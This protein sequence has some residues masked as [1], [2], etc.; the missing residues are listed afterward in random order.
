MIGIYEYIDYEVLFLAF[1]GEPFPS[2]IEE[3]LEMGGRFDGS[4]PITVNDDATI[5]VAKA[6]RHLKACYL[7][8]RRTDRIA[9]RIHR[10]ENL[11]PP[12]DPHEPE[13][14]RITEHT[15]NNLDALR[16]LVKIERNVILTIGETIKFLIDG[17]SP[18]FNLGN[19]PND[20]IVYGIFRTIVSVRMQHFAHAALKPTEPVKKINISL[21]KAVTHTLVRIMLEEGLNSIDQ[22]INYLIEIINTPFFKELLSVWNIIYRIDLKN[23]VSSD[24][25]TTNYLTDLLHGNTDPDEFIASNAYTIMK[26]VELNP[27]ERYEI[28]TYIKKVAEYRSLSEMINRFSVRPLHLWPPTWLGIRLSPSTSKP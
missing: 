25:Y 4:M 12:S 13:N 3:Y 15:W 27:E 10:L 1:Y 17:T 18:L 22:T 11:K 9:S 2:E 20:T 21:P 14:I 8:K 19:T 28:L 6:V 23:P 24:D 5:N 26:S 16:R 7:N